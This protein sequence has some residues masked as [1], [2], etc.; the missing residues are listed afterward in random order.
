MLI[1]KLLERFDPVETL[2]VDVNEV[3]DALIEFGV[4]DEI[5]FHFVS[6]DS[7]KIRAL[8]HRYTYQNSVYGDPIFHSDIIIARDQGEEDESWQRL[9]ATKELLHITDCA[10]ITAES[11]RAVEKLFRHLSLPSELRTP[12]LNTNS[13]LNDRM[14]IF[15]ALAILVPKKCRAK[16]RELYDKDLLS[17]REIALLARIPERYG[18]VVIGEEFD[19][20]INVFT[21]W[22]NTKA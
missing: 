3:R 15:L 8:L 1:D 11:Q 16:L 4:Q 12:D 5:E 20:T 13:A 2:P 9:G 19:T 10:N 22:E 6:I 14:R 17:P 18:D 7:Q 21:A